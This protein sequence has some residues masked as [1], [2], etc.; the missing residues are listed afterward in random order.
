MGTGV[1]HQCQ[2]QVPQCQ[3]ALAWAL[4]GGASACAGDEPTD[5]ATAGASMEAPRRFWEAWTF[6]I[7]SA[8]GV[9]RALRGQSPEEARDT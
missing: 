2:Q 6:P 7:F 4:H 5:G 1:C 9:R 3:L 8:Q